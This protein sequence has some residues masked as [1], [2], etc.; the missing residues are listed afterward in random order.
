MRQWFGKHLLSLIFIF[1]GAFFL[2]IGLIFVGVG[3]SSRREVDRLETLP[4][5]D[6]AGLNDTAAGTEALLEGR[7]SERNPFQFRPFVAYIR[8][9]YQGQKCEDNL[10]DDD[11]SLDCEAVWVEDERVTPP[12]WLDLPGGRARLTNTSYNIQNPGFTQQSTPYLIERETKFY[13]GF[14]I[15]DPVVV[16]GTVAD[17]PEGPAFRATVVSGGDRPTYLANQRG[18]ARLF[19][20]IGGTFSGLGSLLIIVPIILRLVRK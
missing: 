1:V 19:T 13:R 5:L 16:A 17:D 4:L 6:L 15:G 10:N 8:Q 11:N 7:V 18:E 3:M 12:L 20:G 9:E 14:R 2:L